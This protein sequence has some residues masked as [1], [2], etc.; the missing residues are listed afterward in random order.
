MLPVEIVVCANN[1]REHSPTQKR[2]KVATKMRGKRRSEVLT[3]KVL[4]NTMGTVPLNSSSDSYGCTLRLAKLAFSG[5][6]R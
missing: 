5:L 4:T 3:D 6:E 2:E 1:A